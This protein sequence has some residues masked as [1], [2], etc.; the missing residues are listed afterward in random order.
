M[1]HKLWVNAAFDVISYHEARAVG[2]RQHN[3]SPRFGHRLQK[4][5]LF[6]VVEYPEAGGLYDDSID[7]LT[8]RVFI[9]APLDDYYFPYAVHLLSPAAMRATASLRSSRASC[10]LLF[11]L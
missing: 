11:I 9:V 4:L 1:L 6:S 2:V 7:H 5:P 8:E 10:P 3:K